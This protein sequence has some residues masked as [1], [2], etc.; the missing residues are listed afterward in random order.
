M[1]DPMIFTRPRRYFFTVRQVAQIIAEVPCCGRPH[2]LL[3]LINCVTDP[4]T[5]A[6]S[7]LLPTTYRVVRPGG[8]GGAEKGRCGG[9]GVPFGGRFD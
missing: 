5:L 1:I 8:S 2:V 4:E 9:R 3:A 7:E 6:V